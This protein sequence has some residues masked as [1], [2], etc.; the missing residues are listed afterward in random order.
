[1][2]DYITLANRYLDHYSRVPSVPFDE[3]I[4]R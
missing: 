1:M 2:P 4:T 3:E